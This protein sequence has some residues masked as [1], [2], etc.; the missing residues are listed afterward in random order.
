MLARVITSEGKPEQ[1]EAVLRYF[2]ENVGPAARKMMG[3]KGAY[4][5][6]DRKS[7][8]TLG[9]ALWD[10]DEHL[11][12]SAQMTARLGVGMAQAAAVTKPPTVEVYEV[13]VQL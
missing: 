6:V 3:F 13:A 7:G 8:K 11:Q 2:R 5:L 1:L 12:A 10:T 9:M 4:F